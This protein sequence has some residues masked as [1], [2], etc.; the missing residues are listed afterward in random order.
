MRAKEAAFKVRFMGKIGEE[1]WYLPADTSD[2][3]ILQAVALVSSEAED[4]PAT[5]AA[6]YQLWLT[7]K[8]EKTAIDDRNDMLAVYARNLAA[9]PEASVLAVLTKMSGESRWWPAWAEIAAELGALCGWRNQLVTALRNFLQRRKA[10][11]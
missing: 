10:I 2:D 4:R 5:R 6:L 11:P 1:I 7:T 9:Y 8:H 3:T